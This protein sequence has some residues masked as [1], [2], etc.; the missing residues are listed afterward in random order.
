MP[1][2]IWP[3]NLC[4]HSSNTFRRWPF[5]KTFAEIKLNFVHYVFFVLYVLLGFLYTVTYRFLWRIL[6]IWR[7]VGMVRKKRLLYRRNFMEFPH[8]TIWDGIT[9]WHRLMGRWL[10]TS[11][12]FWL[13][14]LSCI[15]YHRQL[16]WGRQ[17]VS[18]SVLFDDVW[19]C[20]LLHVSEGTPI[21]TYRYQ[22][23]PFGWCTRRN[24]YGS[25]EWTDP[26]SFSGSVW[27][28]GYLP[29]GWWSHGTIRL[30]IQEYKK[31]GGVPIYKGKYHYFRPPLW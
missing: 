4:R 18:D 30:S 16:Y 11:G 31:V 21:G 10:I 27:G 23:V 17:K 13:H 5:K 24:L 20:L 3:L 28:K 29:L 6:W 9:E 1:I 14:V 22:I 12:I 25:Q 15:I 2:W 26:L 19:G 7:L 8:D